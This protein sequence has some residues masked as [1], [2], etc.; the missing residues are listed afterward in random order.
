MSGERDMLTEPRR[1]RGFV[2]MEA[3]AHAPQVTRDASTE[4]GVTRRASRIPWDWAAFGVAACT[5]IVV[6][7]Y[8]ARGWTFFYDEWGVI[9]YRRTGGLS[10]FL[11]PLNGHLVA[12]PVAVYR[13]LFSTVGLSSYTPYRWVQITA[14]VAVCALL[15]AYARRRLPGVLAV[16]C[17]VPVLFLGQAWEVLFWMMNLGFAFPLIALLGILLL[18]RSDGRWS[19]PRRAGLLGVALASSGLGIAVAATAF[20]ERA[21]RRRWKDVAWLTLPTAVYAAWFLF[22]RPHANTPAALRVI[23]GAAPHGDVGALG[24]SSGSLRHVP[25]Y[26]FH[27]A[28]SAASGLLGAQ[29]SSG[30]PHLYWLVLVVGLIAAGLILTRRISSTFAAA[31][32]G[33]G[34]FWLLASL[35]R[36]EV[37]QPYASR[38]IYPGAVFI[39]LMIIEAWSGFTWTRLRSP[40][41][42][43]VL[44]LVLSAAVAVVAISGTLRMR[45]IGNSAAKAFARTQVALA[46]LQCPSHPLAPT[47]M[48]APS[49][50]PVDY[51]T[52][53]AAIRDLGSPVPATTLRAVCHQAPLGRPGTARSAG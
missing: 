20:T 47:F 40:R 1:Q 2:A 29:A 38:Y 26:I 43:N 5:A 11:A 25:A 24:V 28:D 21:L 42:R 16:V 9:N 19:G 8:F 31:L 23:P 32:V 34:V 13:L 45:Y 6:I 30:Q 35:A 14:H 37:Q 18:A 51:G 4:I 39:V 12:I 15:F 44:V 52:Y 22:Y 49:Q 50:L 7:A 53:L 33:A 41:R 46:R 27:V 48:P 17:V 3:I 10:A 36:A